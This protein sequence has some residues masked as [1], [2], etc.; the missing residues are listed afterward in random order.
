MDGV[1]ELYR[2]FDNQQRRR[3]AGRVVGLSEIQDGDIIQLR[4]EEGEAV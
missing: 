3:P 2:F 1:N 4:F